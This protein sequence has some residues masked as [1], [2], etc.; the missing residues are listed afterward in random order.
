M[1]GDDT[2]MKGTANKVSGL[3]LFML[4]KIIALASKNEVVLRMMIHLFPISE[5]S[6]TTSHG[7]IW[8]FMSYLRCRSPGRVDHEAFYLELSHSPFFSRVLQLPIFVL[9]TNLPFHLRE[10]FLAWRKPSS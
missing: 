6:N 2:S 4:T 9:P 8:A 10:Y 1:L 3:R 5:H 7:V